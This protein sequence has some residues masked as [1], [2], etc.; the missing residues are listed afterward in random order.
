MPT[1]RSESDTVIDDQDWNGMVGLIK[2]G[3][4][5]SYRSALPQLAKQC[6]DMPQSVKVVDVGK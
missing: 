3:E 5:F 4:F 1:K 6:S 2:A